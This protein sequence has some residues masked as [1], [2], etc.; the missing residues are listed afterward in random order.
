MEEK[1]DLLSLTNKQAVDMDDFKLSVTAY[2]L[3]CK[4]LD[5]VKME[6]AQDR[7]RKLPSLIRP[8]YTVLV[9]QSEV[10]NGGFNQ[11]FWNSSGRLA[12]E[13][14]D[15]L[16][17]LDAKQHAALLKYAIMIEKDESPM[18]AEFKKPQT[19]DSFAESYKH[20][21]LEPLDDEFYKL[22]K[23]DKFRADHIRKNLQEI[24]GYFQ[25]Q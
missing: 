1:V 21:E 5:G 7:V 2:E 15:D 17:C 12:S 6:K 9:L 8:L 13:A 4:P 10:E 19:W 23:L 22:P 14:L 25:N 16:V 18:M 3:I 11:Y 24:Q 20:T